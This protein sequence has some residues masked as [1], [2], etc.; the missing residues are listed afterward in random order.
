MPQAKSEEL[1]D[2][3]KKLKKNNVAVGAFMTLMALSNLTHSTDIVNFGE[4][5][6]NQEKLEAFIAAVNNNDNRY[7]F[8]ERTWSCSV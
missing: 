6:A 5:R 7:V 3:A 2:L 4:E 1:V 8:L